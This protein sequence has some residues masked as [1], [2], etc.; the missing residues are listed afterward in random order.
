MAKAEIETTTNPDAALIKLIAKYEVL[1]G[2][3]AKLDEAS[4]MARRMGELSRADD[5][6]RR[7]DE[8]FNRACGLQWELLHKDAKSAEGHAAKIRMVSGSSFDPEDLIRIAWLLGCEAG[9]LGLSKAMPR[10]APP[11][12]PP[13]MAAA[14]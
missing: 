5:L 9:R 8:T 4:L 13:R 2:E 3:S 11:V 1:S 12:V 6:R 10:L 14:E 7:C